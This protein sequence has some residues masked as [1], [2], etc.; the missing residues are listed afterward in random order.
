MQ[1]DIEKASAAGL[2]VGTIDSD[3]PSSKALFFLG[4]NKYQAGVTG[5]QRL[6]RE[7]H[8]KGNV[9]VFTMP[10]QANLQERL[11][12]YRDALESTPQNKIVRVVDIKGDPRSAFDSAHEIIGQERDKVEGVR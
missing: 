5:G 8:G 2:P 10:E 3:A 12:G 11:R 4:T 1:G 9:V 7:L 6:A